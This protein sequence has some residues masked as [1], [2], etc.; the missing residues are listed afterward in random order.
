M[1]SN[2]LEKERSGEGLNHMTSDMKGQTV[3][4]AGI[5]Q[6]IECGL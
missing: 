1:T 2:M 6:Q 3:T 5:A 4:L